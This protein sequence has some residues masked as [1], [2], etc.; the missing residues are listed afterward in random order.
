M[1]NQAATEFLRRLVLDDGLRD[2]VRAAEKGR[3]EKAPVL[4]E[5]GTRLGLDFT[6]AELADVLDALHRHKIGELSEEDLIEVAG[7]LVSM[8]GW[9][10]AHD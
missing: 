4:V 1:S 5:Q 2:Q 8:P 9:H 3:A 6:V 10:P 7:G